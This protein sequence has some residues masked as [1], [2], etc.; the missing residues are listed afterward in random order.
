MALN[1]SLRANLGITLLLLLALVASG[2]MVARALRLIGDPEGD[3]AVGRDRV[4]RHE[5]RLAG[6][7]TV[8]P[9]RGVVG[10]LSDNRAA[11]GFSDMSAM[12]EYFM[13]QYALAP[14]VI[15]PGAD[16]DTVVGLFSRPVDVNP[17]TGL[18]ILGNF[19]DGVL[20]MKREER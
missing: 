14:L 7:R 4:A 2:Q 19:G 13:T 17:S 10:Y 6:L 5:E 1:R 8:L 16:R 18:R 11:D 3:D 12:E 15:V 20:L 9:E